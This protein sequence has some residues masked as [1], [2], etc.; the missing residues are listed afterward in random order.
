MSDAPSTLDT[1]A[2]A[3]ALEALPAKTPLWWTDA[4]VVQL[5]VR[6]FGD[7][8]GDGIGDLAGITSRMGYLRNLGV[9]AIWLNPCY[10]SPQAD[11]GYD[12]SDYLAIE[13]DYGTLGD[14]DALV[15]EAGSMGLR[16][17]MDIVPNHCSSEHQWFKS[18]LQGGRGSSEREWFYFRDGKGDKGEQPPNNWQAWF[19]GP[20]WNRIIEADGRPGQWYLAMF[21]PDQPDLNWTTEPVALAFDDILR[22][23]WDRGVEGFRIDAPAL[24]G[25]TPGLPDAPPV[26]LGTPATDTAAHNPHVFHR[27]EVHDLFRR[28]RRVAKDYERSHPGRELVLVGETFAPS[29]EV[30]ASYVNDAELH[31]TFFFDLLLANWTPTRWRNAICAAASDLG[32]KGVR[33]AW[34]L[35]NHDAQRNTTR[36]GHRDAHLE[37]SFSNNNLVNSSEPVN[38][39]IGNRRARAAIMI[40]A[41]LPGPVFLYAGEELGLPEVL[42]LPEEAL[43][44]PI[45][46]RTGHTE[47]G[48]DG[49]RVP[50]P[51]TA[52]PS[53]NYGF[54]TGTNPA[55]PWL[56]QPGGW[57]AFA[58][59]AQIG[60][61][62][63]MFN[64]YRRMLA[65][66][67]SL[68]KQTHVQ[69]V[70]LGDSIVAFR[71]GDVICAANISDTPV[72]LPAGVGEILAGSVPLSLVDGRLSLPADSTVWCR[73]SLPGPLATRGLGKRG[74]GGSELPFAEDSDPAN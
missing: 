27:P 63:S 10:P 18:A 62:D 12:V 36:Y 7:A 72:A 67:R 1:A 33:F 13:P 30:V 26:P 43:Q 31:T 57:G 4:V 24:V 21:T 61:P 25:K 9:D 29:L 66:R 56:P 8:N 22:F 49:C 34:A 32:G 41:A 20:A 14:F 71:R 45:W 53:T 42:D 3:P 70:E 17:L 52:D 68:T 2:P 48:R 28:W 50:L 58:A 46:E 55:A 6:S 64:L 44:D 60:D 15:A 47:R 51:W 59:D 23:W 19:G 16:V 74:A 5:Y 37:S 35:N 54:S 11:H 65:L 40:L 38:P 69:M 73:H 39:E